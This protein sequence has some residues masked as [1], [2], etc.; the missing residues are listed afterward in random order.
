MRTPTI[1]AL[2][3]AW[4]AFM[5]PATG[6]EKGA[7]GSGV[8]CLKSAADIYMEIRITQV[9]AVQSHIT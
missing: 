7:T 3:S 1:A 6:A 4:S 2:D 5:W 8:A 9:A